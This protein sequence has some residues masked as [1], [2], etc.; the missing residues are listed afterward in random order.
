[1]SETN[2][3]VFVNGNIVIFE[4][5]ESSKIVI[6]EAL[7]G[8]PMMISNKNGTKVIIEQPIMN[9]NDKAAMRK[10]LLEVIEEFREYGCPRMEFPRW[11]EMMLYPVVPESAD[12]EY[13]CPEQ[14]IDSFLDSYG[15]EFI[16]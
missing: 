8:Y 15:P 4:Y 12:V 13:W 10:C 9:P 1:M 16:I 2:C 6:P 5:G 3:I 11:N 7:M 14:V